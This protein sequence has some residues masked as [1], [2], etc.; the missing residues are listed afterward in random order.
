MSDS[1]QNPFAAPQT[2]MSSASGWSG[3]PQ[4]S[5]KIEAVIKEA[6]QFWIALLLCLFCSGIGSLIIGVWYIVRLFQWNG[7]ARANPALLERGAP[8]GSLPFRFQTART[9]LIIGVCAGFAILL[10]QIALLAIWVATAEPR[11]L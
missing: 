9:K 7:L 2:G 5:P 1:N 8:P 10:V 4:S 6:N 11:R 3:D